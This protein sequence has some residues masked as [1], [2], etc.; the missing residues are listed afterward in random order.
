VGANGADAG[1]VARVRQ[2][3][4]ALPGVLLPPP[5]DAHGLASAFAAAAINVHPCL[6]DAY[7]MTI[8]EAAAW[9]V[10]SVVHCPAGAQSGAPQ[11]LDFIPMESAHGAWNVAV[12]K[13]RACGEWAEQLARECHA[14]A[15]TL[16]PVGACDL[17]APS[18]NDPSSSPG[19][20][21]WDW[22][23]APGDVKAEFCAM[24]A[25]ASALRDSRLRGV[26]VPQPSRLEAIAAAGQTR[27]LAWS[28]KA[29]GLALRSFISDV[30]DSRAAS[31]GAI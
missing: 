27:A 14:Q 9:G 26:P 31:D 25:D 29:H 13:A 23:R 16:P 22:S 2:A 19:V 7:G 18:P 4:A 1:Y 12:S 8:V 10:P 24:L 21:A 3:A 20:V 28:E 5:L 17:L 11:I 6:A 30:I 15:A